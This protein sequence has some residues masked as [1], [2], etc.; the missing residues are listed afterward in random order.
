MKTCI[1]SGSY[2][3]ITIG[4]LDIIK[5]AKDIFDRVIVVMLINPEKSYCFTKEQRLSMLN[6][7]LDKI[8]KVDF[9]GGYTVDYCKAKGI[10]H[11]I[12]GIRNIE[13]YKYEYRIDQINKSI[14]PEIETI[15]LPSK[16][17]LNHISST[18]IREK[19]RNNEDI[20]KLVPLEIIDMIGEYY[21][22]Y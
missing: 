11:I 17:E 21:G 4:H 6:K 1:V 14:N 18:L 12:R 2:D 5:R 9:Y 7:A 22:E 8:A 3:P 19:L 13:Q 10:K 16:S 15:Y 20:S